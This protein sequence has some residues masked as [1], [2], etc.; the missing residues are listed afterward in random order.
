MLKENFKV[1]GVVPNWEPAISKKGAM[2]RYLLPTILTKAVWL[3]QIPQTSQAV[4]VMEHTFGSVPAA[5]EMV[6]DCV[7][8]E[9][10]IPQV[11]LQL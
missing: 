7:D 3:A 11:V 9:N 8:G 2:L 10:S 6:A 5:N 1:R 4:P